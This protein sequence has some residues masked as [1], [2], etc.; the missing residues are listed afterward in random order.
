MRR[1]G[2]LLLPALLPL[3]CA[4]LPRGGGLESAGPCVAA[5]CPDVFP[6]GSWQLTHA[7]Q[8]LPPDGSSQTL[9][10]V[11]ALFP[12]ERRF[13][14]VMM[15]LEGLVLFEAEYDGSVTVRRAVAPLDRPGMAEGVVEDIRLMFFAPGSPC[16]SAGRS[17][18]GARVCRYPLADDAYEDV[19][20]AA[21]GTWQ[22]RLY[23]P[24]HRLRRTVAP[25]SRD[26]LRPDGLAGGM[27]LK[28][29]GFAGYRLVMRLLEAVPVQP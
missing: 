16:M 15:S 19:L 4:P 10:G 6:R 25:A 13:R 26:D 12:G 29:E 2:A 28:A 1:L 27:E 3:A 9:I 8:F 21:D 11:L 18:E 7:V 24:D 17:P 20:L 14:C 23:G 22:I 5:E